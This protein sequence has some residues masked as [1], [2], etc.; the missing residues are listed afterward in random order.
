MEHITKEQKAGFDL[1]LAAQRQDCDAVKRYLEPPFNADADARSPLGTTALFEAIQFNRKD[2]AQLLLD[3]EADPNAKAGEALHRCTPLHATVIKDRFD[4]AKLLLGHG[5]NPF[6]KDDRGET[7]ED[8]ARRT[9]KHE[10]AKL[11]AEAKEH[12]KRTYLADEERSLPDSG[13][14]ASVPKPNATHAE[15]AA[16]RNR[17]A[18][19][20][21]YQP[22]D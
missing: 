12:L 5:A 3:Y 2:I 1:L 10:L 15:D 4:M 6:T 8:L 9:G 7:P 19:L 20:L 11:L 22:G 16:G 14:A 21:A 13:H 18:G 17:G